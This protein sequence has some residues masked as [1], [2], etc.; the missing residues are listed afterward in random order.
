MLEIEKKFLLTALQ[1]ERLLDGAEELGGKTVVDSYFDTDSYNLTTRDY[2]LRNRNGIYELKA[3]LKSRSSVDAT[4]RY[5]EITDLSEIAKEL[6]LAES[7]DFETSLS[8]AGV[9]RFMSCRTDRNSYK[10]DEFHIDIDQATYPDSEF[11]YGVAEIE[12]IV[13]TEVEA[14]DAE[15]RIIEFAQSFDL[16]VDQIV[17]GK[18]AAYLKSEKPDHHEALVTAGVLK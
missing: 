12:L 9:K 7:D 8:L 16:P 4:N 6:D 13:Q 5:Y 15:Q 1:K 2:W 18:V 3:P 10:K 14:D 17:L 11:E